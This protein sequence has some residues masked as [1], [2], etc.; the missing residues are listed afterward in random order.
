MGDVTV[1]VRSPFFISGSGFW[2]VMTSGL[3]CGF[4]IDGLI[5]SLTVCIDEWMC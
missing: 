5:Y 2:V 4:V 1:Q 3:Q